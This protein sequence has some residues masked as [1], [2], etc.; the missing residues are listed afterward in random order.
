MKQFCREKN[1]FDFRFCGYW[2]GLY[3]YTKKA[4]KGFY[5]VSCNDDD[6]DND[7]LLF[8]LENGYTRAVI[9]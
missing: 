2:D 1:A 9:K 7:N 5:T 8:M 3:H 6:F 4:S